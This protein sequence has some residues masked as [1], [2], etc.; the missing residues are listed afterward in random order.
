MIPQVD[1]L[2]C[3]LLYLTRQSAW[4]AA[5]L[6]WSPHA[7]PEWRNR[8]NQWNEEANELAECRAYDWVA[9]E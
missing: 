6:W 5:G 2:R 8:A 3:A 7:A 4:S 1:L 9:G